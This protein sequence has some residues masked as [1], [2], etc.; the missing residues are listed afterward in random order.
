VCRAVY[1]QR[2]LQCWA[3]AVTT[4]RRRRTQCVSRP[5]PPA[6]CALVVRLL[7]ACASAN[8][9]TCTFL[10]V[11]GRQVLA[12]FKRVKH[13]QMTDLDRRAFALDFADFMNTAAVDVSVQLRHQPCLDWCG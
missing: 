12:S 8:G 11:S 4:T 7:A 2:R 3:V 5:P 13:Q 10:C 1:A 9:T 6:K